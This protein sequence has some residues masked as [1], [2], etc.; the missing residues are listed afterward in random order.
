[1][2]NFHFSYIN[3]TILIMCLVAYGRVSRKGKRYY[4]R[5]FYENQY[6]YSLDN[7]WDSERGLFP[8]VN[9]LALNAIISA[10]ATCG[11]SGPEVYCKLVE[12]VFMREPQC[13]VCDA[14]SNNTEHRHPIINAI[15]G[16]NKWWKSPT[17]QNGKRFEWVTIT[18][19]LKQMFQIAYIIV[20][21]A[22]SPRPGNWILER[23]KD[24]LIYKPWQYYAINDAECYE[25]FGIR[26]TMGKPRYRSDDEVICTSYYSKL[27]PLDGGEI[28]TS[29][30]NGRPGAEDPSDTLREFTAARYVRLRLQKIRTLNADLMTM[31]SYDPQKID[32]STTRRY[33][34]S[35]KDISVG[36]QC[37]CYGHAKQ[38]P[39]TPELKLFQCKCEHN[40]CGE[41]C[42]QCCP[43]YQQKPWRPGNLND[44]AACE[45]CQ[46]YGHAD[47]CF[48]DQTV[49]DKKASLNINEEYEGGGVCIRCKHHTTGINCEQCEDGYYRPLG[50]E[51]NDPEPCRRCRCAGKGVTGFCVKDD[52]YILE[53]IYP[54]DCICKEGFAGSRCD[55][56][57]LGYKTY[58]VCEPCPCDPSGTEG[59]STC[60][61]FCVCKK[62]VEGARCEYCKQGHYNL[63][64]ENSD[65]CTACY[66]SGITTRCQQSDWGVKV[67]QTLDGWTVSD[68]FGLHVAHPLYEGDYLK[69]TNEAMLGFDNYY[70]SAP[71]EYLGKKLYSYG[72]E[73]R[74]VIGYSVIE[75]DGVQND[76]PGI[77]LES[78]MIRIG[79]YFGSRKIQGNITVTL[80]LQE[81]AWSH[82]TAAGKRNRAVSRETFAAVMNN[83]S[84]ILIRAKYHSDQVIGILYNVEMEIADRGSS[85]LKKMVTVEMCECPLGYSGLSCE[86]CETGYRRVNEILHKGVCEICQCNGHSST[87][88]PFTSYCKSCAHNTTGHRCE[89]CKEGFHGNPL[90]GSPEDCQPCACP[91]LNEENNFSPTCK[92]IVTTEG[93][94]DYI[95]TACAVGYIGNKCQRCAPGYFGTPGTPGGSCQPCDCTGNADTFD[96]TYCDHITGQC[97]KC[98]G[99]TGG[100]HCNEC[101]EGHYGNAYHHVCKPCGCHPLGSENSICDR[102]TGLCECKLNYNG[103]ECDRCDYGLGNIEL[104]CLPCRC[105][106][107]GTIHENVDICDPVS[108]KCDCKPGV[109]GLKCDT[110]LEGY[111]SFSESGCKWCG[112]DANGAATPQCEDPSGQCVCKKN[113][114]GKTCN[115]CAPETWNLLS[116][117]GCEDC[118]CDE[119]GSVSLVCD[120][121]NGICT[122]KPGVGGDKCDMCLQGYFGFSTTGCRKCEPCQ[123][124]GHVCDP[125]TGLCVCP[126]NTEG[127]YCQRCTSSS[128]GYDPVQGCKLCDCNFR[129]SP[130][131]NICDVDNGNC[132]CHE[133]YEG[134]RCDKCR[135]AHYQFPDCMRCEC[136]YD[137]TDPSQCTAEGLC[138][139][140]EN[141]QCPCK[142]NVEGVKC[143]FCKPGTFGLAVDN[144][145]GCYECFCFGRSKDC[146]QAEM[147][148]SQITTP[149]R[150]VIFELGNTPLG[151]SSHKFLLIPGQ[152]GN[153]KLG[154]PYIIAQPVY[155]MLPKEFLG[156]K[157]RSYNG[158]LKFHIESRSSRRYPD[159]QL[160]IYPLVVIEGNNRNLVHSPFMPISG[161]KYSVRFRE[162]E[163]TQRENPEVPVTRALLMLVLQNVQQILIRATEGADVKISSGNL[164]RIKDVSME[165]A[166][167][168]SPTPASPY[169]AVGVEICKCPKEYSGLSCQDPGKGYYRK[170]KINFQNST[171]LIDQIG[172]SVPCPCNNRSDICDPETGFCQNCRENTA[173]AFCELCAKGFFG[174]PTRSP[175]Q[176]CECP[177]VNNSFSDTCD[178]DITGHVCTNCQLGYEGKHCEKCSRGFYGTP[179]MMGGQCLACNCN[180]Y[181]SLDRICDRMT[182]QCHCRRGI[183]GRDCTQ[184]SP[185]H[186]LTDIGCKSCDDHCIGP[187]LNDVDFLVESYAKHNLSTFSPRPWIPLL[188]IDNQTIALQKSILK[189]YNVLEEG[190]NISRHF[191]ADFDFETLADLMYLRGRDINIRGPIVTFDAFE[192]KED[193]DVLFKMLEKIWRSIHG[194]VNHLQVQGA[195][196]NF[197]AAAVEEKI[198]YSE[199]VLNVLKS[200]DIDMIREESEREMRKASQILDAVQN[201]IMDFKVF[202]AGEETLRSLSDLLT[203][204]I[205]LIERRIRLTSVKS[206]VIV[207]EARE[208]EDKI[209]NDISEGEKAKNIAKENLEVSENLLV[210]SENLLGN[211]SVILEKA[212]PLQ[213]L[214]ENATEQ[215]E[216]HRGILARLNPRYIQKFVVPAAEH[217]EHISQQALYLS[218]L[219]KSAQVASKF[220]LMAAKVY[221]DI[222]DNIES[223]VIAAR[224][225]LSDAQRTYNE[226]DPNFK[227]SI[228]SQATILHKRSG[229]LTNQA[230]MR[231]IEVKNLTDD[232]KKF[233][234][235]IKKI[236]D[237]IMHIVTSL[238]EFKDDIDVLPRD[239]ADQLRTAE[240]RHR[241][242]SDKMV[243]L[244]GKIDM[245]QEMLNVELYD[246][247]N[248]LRVGSTAGLFNITKTIDIGKEITKAAIKKAGTAESRVDRVKSLNNQMQ[249]SVRNLKNKILLARQKASNIRVSL[250]ADSTGICVRSYRPDIE[251]T[252][253]SSIVLHYAIKTDDKDSLLL[254]LA[255]SVSDDFM[256]VEMVN[257]K[258]RFIWNAG[259]GTQVIQHKL[260]IETNDAQLLKDER[261]YKISINRF[262]NI[263][264]LSVKPTLYINKEDPLM[265]TDSSPP[266]FSKMDLD[267]SSF[268]YIGGTP[269]GFRVPRELKARNFAGCLYELV[270]DGKKVGL[271]NFVTNQGC[272]GCKEGAAE[273][274]DFAAYSFR[275]DGYAILP[276]IKRYNKRYYVIA[277][278]FKTFDED[279]LLFFSP[280]NESGEFVS[281]ELRGGYVVYQFSLGSQFRSVLKTTKK[282]NNGTWVRLTAQRENFQGQLQVGD[283]FLDGALPKNS[284][285][286]LDLQK[287]Y[288]FF[289]GV[290]PNFT[291]NTWNGIGFQK[292]FGCMKDLQID[293]TILDLLQN[294]SYGVERSCKDIPQKSVGFRGSGFIEMP[295]ISLGE[296]SSFS[297]SFQTTQTSAVLLLST[298]DTG[299]NFES[300]KS[301]YYSVA[302]IDGLIEAR[303]NGGSGETK[304]ISDEL[305]ND[306]R[307][308]SITIMKTHRKIVMRVDDIEVGSGRLPKGM[309]DID[310]P[311][312]RGLYFGG[313]RQGIDYKSMISTKT[314]LFGTIKDPIFNNR[315]LRFDEYFDFN[316]A[317]IGRTQTDWFGM[318]APYAGIVRPLERCSEMASYVLENR[319]VKFGDELSSYAKVPIGR[320]DFVH[321]F[322]VTFDIRTYFSNGLLTL[323]KN[324]RSVSHF[325][326]MLLGGRAVIN[327]FDRKARRATNPA[328]LND[329]N[330]HHI[331]VNKTGRQMVFSVDYKKRGI[332]FKVRRRLAL[333]SPLYVGGVPEDME[334]IP[335]VVMESFRGCIRNFNLNGYYLDIASSELHNVG[336]C[337]STIEPGASFSGDAY[338]I[339]ADK[340]NLG[341]KLDVQV[342]F[343]TTRQNGI[344]LALSEGYGIPSIALELGNG[345]IVLSLV[346]G[347][348]EKPFKTVKTFDSPYYLCDGQWHMVT[349]QYA[350]KTVTLKVDLFDLVIGH[351]SSAPLE[352]TTSSPL[353]I[354]GIPDNL[355]SGALHSRSNFVGCLRNLAINDRRVEWIDMASRHHVLPN[356]C[357]TF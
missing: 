74:Y 79:Y 164:L 175:C 235:R 342:E 145:L 307:W 194:A 96:P 97:L 205:H 300:K 321:D 254:F 258:I 336:H 38:C 329:G 48:Y 234:A 346:L 290:P 216:H 176:P 6:Y 230:S 163:W 149:P 45:K 126:P 206:S 217:A 196:L 154:I 78:D 221:E 227:N 146:K 113:V 161:G 201:V 348:L 179:T 357:P 24:G 156:E 101:L 323:V 35:I 302:L 259:G 171:D 105:N 310:A 352:P 249:S 281:L 61:G 294:S 270:L 263:A 273:V 125:D 289:G 88:D 277:L 303:F 247:L 198:A 193:S 181:G 185:R 223:A 296:E 245:L 76:A 5:T 120:E 108:G 202:T 210:E 349:A 109:F 52:S 182:G 84:K 115:Q 267:S 287:S 119:L 332:N 91:L 252:S 144:P 30:V 256:I 16:T 140:D 83:L 347:N 312:Q 143:E 315:L 1:M 73:L 26:P 239:I 192:V 284:P 28:H 293:S 82:L 13:G 276:Q 49:A 33:F 2:L 335:K 237:D 134:R 240:D 274:A 271:W 118:K 264:T 337:F 42:E 100:W 128:W 220:P 170:K 251:P 228:S 306:G 278:H 322:N 8:S 317:G 104:G 199:D 180:P 333:R 44:G 152:N 269:K 355:P 138:Q 195:N 262:G 130:S 191:V 165:V 54:G 190:Q 327:M 285:K 351:S 151:L 64:A 225:T 344:I 208:I 291:T 117:K 69:I 232:I 50:V 219:F 58:P 148:L 51:R 266:G 172:I 324:G 9:N 56:C 231:M 90:R 10:N 166:V 272:D 162:D 354:G 255:S 168:L 211:V 57:A 214:M 260:T 110:C 155:W 308:H 62:N 283:E 197:S 200:R 27:N 75:D 184:C 19:D 246:R 186:I 60:E 203:E 353:F 268:F 55:H 98:I 122:C 86:I 222:I 37:V 187:L 334:P 142:E 72:G 242:I 102:D 53:G 132:I 314:P 46:C 174:D 137:G 213:A 207:C 59:E 297:I 189:Y 12:H 280:N 159:P 282:Y 114:I 325:S 11:E 129:G 99:N 301:H 127:E 169:V 116:G 309:K 253:T 298:F 34:Y 188:Q 328:H 87:C 20:K 68:I 326:L 40:T 124:S 215:L 160:F 95:C 157:T 71:P 41:N 14:R 338:A 257:R 31:Q 47:I 313:F 330:W 279:A 77:I 131:D 36:G 248:Y 93:A 123:N 286:T 173:G 319:A 341:Q 103:R 340:F 311:P 345:T 243:L 233:K 39:L 4:N 261:W 356:A 43:L 139:C 85:S 343:K 32:K 158:V 22:I 67:I 183:T 167:L 107:T 178:W 66:C 288:L 15:D 111:Y 292:F 299:R 244:H 304:I 229:K 136:R 241:N 89:M 218:N 23:S 18:L 135:F 350:Y 121:F 275:G 81:R 70:W 29:L 250:S 112:C 25:A 177:L 295:G 141:G 17:L 238:A 236:S 106:K 204:F 316:G 94:T 92:D 318:E 305:Y 80:P 3:L 224:K 147:V 265:V 63:D 339:Y 21:A 150:E 320:K 212:M 153:V 65:G 331:S 7:S 226:A 133:G 209:N